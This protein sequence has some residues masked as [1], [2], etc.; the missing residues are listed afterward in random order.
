V[1]V[2]LDLEMTGLDPARHVI[3]EIASLVTD[4]DLEI[5]AEGPDVVIHQPAEALAA[6]DDVVRTMHG[7]S[8]LLTAIE[9]STTSL[10]EAGRMTLEFVKTH[11]PEARTVP[12]A[13]NSI[14]TCTTGR[15]TC[16]RSRSCAAGG[17]PT[18]WPRRPR[19]RAATGPSMTSGRASP[20]CAT[21]GRPSSADH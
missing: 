15:S 10:A 18:P 16:R 11:A 7:R 12:L 19:R 13:G 9:A 17:T 20:S 21:T 3:V 4:D 6:M 14:G 8:G 5:V 2:W 1:L